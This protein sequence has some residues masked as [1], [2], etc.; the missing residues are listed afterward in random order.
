MWNGTGWAPDCT[1]IDGTFSQVS[2]FTLAKIVKCVWI[3][4]VLFN[5]R[6]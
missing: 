3:S 1:S 6:L 4:L 5:R 2:A